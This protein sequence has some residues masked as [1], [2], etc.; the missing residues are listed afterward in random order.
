M[1]ATWSTKVDASI[2]KPNALHLNDTVIIRKSVETVF[3][4]IVNDLS[5]HYQ[6]TANGHIKF[7]VVGANEITEGA[8]IECQEVADT[9]EVHH[10]YDVTD[11]IP[12]Q[13]IY[14][15]TS[16]PLNPTRAYMQSGNRTI[17]T[18]SATYV[19]YDFEKVS[20]KET[21]LSLSIVIQMP[22]FF[23]KLMAALFGQEKLW[24]NHLSEE[25]KNMK[26]IIERIDP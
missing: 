16:L 23:N 14:F 17:E 22:N 25:L 10:L 8:K 1:N 13:R 21:K 15:S 2:R 20:P 26:T 4:F 12:N 11:V 5:I 6:N 18:L 3:N 7:Q 24:G 9:V 19:Y